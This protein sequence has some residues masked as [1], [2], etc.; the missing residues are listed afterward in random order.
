VAPSA[1][2]LPEG[3]TRAF[4]V[5]LSGSAS[6][7]LHV[8]VSDRLAAMLGDVPAALAAVL[9]AGVEAI[10]GV[11]GD[12]A[13]TDATEVDL[14]AVL[15][16]ADGE[17]LVAPILEGD[18]P[19]ASVVLVMSLTPGD[20]VAA[21]ARHEFPQIEEMGHAMAGPRHLALLNDVELG[22]TAELGRRRLTVREL[23][24]LSPGSVV[25]LDRA[26]GSP[27]DVL[28]NGTLIAR[29]EVVVID[30]EFGIRI[31]EIVSPEAAGQH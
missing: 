26:A 21:V 18:V 12:V 8:V 11:A 31:S 13:A 19:L 5:S 7:A 23:L 1:E 9:A 27:V 15:E 3:P 20:D 25:E 22:V 29:G 14:S 2:V 17:H 4:G 24:S 30:E 6:G 10:A 28:V 16:A